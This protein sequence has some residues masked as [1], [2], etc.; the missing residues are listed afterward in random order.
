MQKYCQAKLANVGWQHSSF[1]ENILHHQFPNKHCAD[2][3]IDSLSLGNSQC[4]G[5]GTWETKQP[6]W[7]QK[8]RL[9]WCSVE[10][11]EARK[12]QG[13][14]ASNRTVKT[15]TWK[16]WSPSKLHE[17][18][19]SSFNDWNSA[20]ASGAS[21]WSICMS[22]LFMPFATLLFSI[23]AAEDFCAHD[24]PK[25]RAALAARKAVAPWA[26]QPLRKRPVCKRPLGWW[27]A[28]LTDTR[29]EAGN[30]AM[31]KW[32]AVVEGLCPSFGLM[33]A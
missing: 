21:I 12:A 5:G 1:A 16:S 29:T 6:R 13:K 15:L 2:G 7:S 9:P 11:L 25:Q 26:R 32:W 27:A 17:A 24:A 33:L 30:V 22:R 8:R 3:A 23:S 20:I 10:A 14:N 18:K 31:R 19:G 28:T 4:V